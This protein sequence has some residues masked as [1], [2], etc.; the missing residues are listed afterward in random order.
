MNVVVVRIPDPDLAAVAPFPNPEVAHQLLARPHQL[1]DPEVTVVTKHKILTIASKAN[2]LQIFIQV[3]KF[4]KKITEFYAVNIMYQRSLTGKHNEGTLPTLKK[5]N[6]LKNFFPH[7]LTNTGSVQNVSSVC[8]CCVKKIIK[9][10]EI[11][12][13]LNQKESLENLR[14]TNNMRC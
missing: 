8:V 3:R 14:C 11:F 13:V 6:L 12:P 10:I 1:L 2:K 5:S 4:L 9:K 7:I